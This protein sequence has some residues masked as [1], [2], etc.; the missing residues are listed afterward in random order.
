[1]TA[2][3]KQILALGAF[4]GRRQDE[5]KRAALTHPH[6]GV[7]VTVGI[8]QFSWEEGEVPEIG[9]DLEIHET[10]K[11]MQ[12]G[13]WAPEVPTGIWRVTEIKNGLIVLRGV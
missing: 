8:G 1:M 6:K 3:R 5:L 10:D 9:M 2:S 4:W 7:E 11:I 12:E 13:R